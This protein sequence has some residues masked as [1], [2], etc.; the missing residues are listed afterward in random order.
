MTAKRKKE[1]FVAVTG[2]G[3]VCPLGI[4]ANECW[5]NMF[6]G[7]SGIRRITQFDAS[8]CLTKI[9]GQLPDKYYEWEKPA[10]SPSFFEQNLLP[11][12]LA[13]L[14]AKQAIEDANILKENIDPLKTAVI[15]GCGGS[16]FGDQVLL[17]SQNGKRVVFTR[18]ML[19]ALSVTVSL[20]FGFK[21]PA[22]NVATA[23]S[24][25][26]VAVGLGYDY[27]RRQGGT[28]VV[29]GIETV[30]VK[31]TIDGFN[32]LMAL[33]EE[34][35]RP[36]KASRP[37]DKRRSGFVLSEG[38]CAV[39][40]ESFESAVRRGAR[41]YAVMSGHGVIS[42]GFNIVAPEPDGKGMARGMEL[43]IENAGIQKEKIGY[44]NAHG[45]STPH[46]D[47]AETKAIKSVFGR[48][49]YKIPVSS[50]KSMIGHTIGAAG[51]IEFGVTALSLYHQALTPTIN[52]E[53]PDPVCDLD[54]VPNTA[55]RNY[56]FEAAITNSFGFGGHNSTIVLERYDT[57]LQ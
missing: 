13:L 44:V 7:K 51:A 20:E 24:A 14:T 15:T 41:I 8:D 5:E 23:C 28:S 11:A 3:L 45:T 43:A 22:Y 31:E 17:S 54:Y 47:P 49:A 30:L 42:E 33:S 18:E 9:G 48:D 27:V 52:Y 26:A 56:S 12:R 40:L 29:M 19:N 4:S 2:I 39:F 55:R 10:L 34:N 1:Q 36:E 50:Q 38:A 37:F 53:E 25:G 46:N 16:T 57:L 35:D 6:Q 32:Q 21:G